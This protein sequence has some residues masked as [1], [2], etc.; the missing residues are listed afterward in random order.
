MN[1]STASENV[2]HHSAAVTYPPNRV[3]G[4]LATA[5]EA[6]ATIQALLRAGFW[7]DEVSVL[8]GEQDLQKLDASGTVNGF[9]AQF[10]RSLMR[11]QSTVE[12]AEYRQHHEDDVRAGRYVVMVHAKTRDRR[13]RAAD[14]LNA[15]GATFVAFYGRWTWE[16]L[17]A[18]TGAPDPAPGR[19]YEARFGDATTRMRVESASAAAVATD[20]DTAPALRG[21]VTTV[22]PGVAMVSWHDDKNR[23][24]VQVHDYGHGTAY[25]VITA[26]G[27]EPRHLEGTVRRIV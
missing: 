9:L 25:A 14:I 12:E 21:T 8:H 2:Q 6:Q 11:G 26:A 20:G 3:V 13:H 17:E 5:A 7:R 23:T 10:R 15:H 4:T 27:T 22:R 16:A 24:T 18:D 19:T 1:E